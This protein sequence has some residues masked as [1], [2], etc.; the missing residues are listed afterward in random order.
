MGKFFPTDLSVPHSHAPIPSPVRP[1]PLF[2]LMF[3]HPETPL[4]A[5]VASIR[6]IVYLCERCDYSYW[7]KAFG[8]RAEKRNGWI[9]LDFHPLIASSPLAFSDL[10][11]VM[12]KFMFARSCFVELRKTCVQRYFFCWN[13]SSDSTLIGNVKNWVFSFKCQIPIS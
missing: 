4:S 12:C 6:L 8:A 1:T 5:L 3:Y 13:S 11:Y 10:L 9:P 2:F 7:C